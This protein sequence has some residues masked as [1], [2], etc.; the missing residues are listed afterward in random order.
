MGNLVEDQASG[1]IRS[2][3]KGER[4]NFE[5]HD[6]QNH[7]SSLFPVRPSL[8]DKYLYAHTF[9]IRIDQPLQKYPI[10]RETTATLPD[11]CHQQTGRMGLNYYTIHTCGNVL[12]ACDA[13]DRNG[14][15]CAPGVLGASAHDLEPGS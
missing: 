8:S 15:P 2:M 14:F 4:G 11:R 12:P 1:F 6:I 9:Q 10:G 3:A 7:K 13:D 5:W